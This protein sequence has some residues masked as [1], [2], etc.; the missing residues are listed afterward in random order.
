MTR[1]QSQR[2]EDKLKANPHVVTLVMQYHDWITDNG[3]RSPEEL[4]RQPLPPDQRALLLE[5]LNDVLTVYGLAS[6]IA[7]QDKGPVRRG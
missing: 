3:G 7:R 2:L 6:E 1:D 4:L 5:L